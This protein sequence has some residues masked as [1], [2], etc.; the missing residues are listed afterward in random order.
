MPRGRPRIFPHGCRHGCKYLCEQCFAEF[1]AQGFVNAQKHF[2]EHG[3][4]KWGCTICHPERRAI[5]REKMRKLRAKRAA[6]ADAAEAAAAA[7]TLQSN[8]DTA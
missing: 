1:A 5:E 8:A 3:K 4:R 6:E 2:C 7:A